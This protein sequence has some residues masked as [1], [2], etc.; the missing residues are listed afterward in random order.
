MSTKKFS[1]RSFLKTA[2]LFAAGGLMAACTPQA[3]P[4]PAAAPVDPTATTA[5]ATE[6]A[7]KATAT[8]VP[9]TAT[10]APT[11][12]SSV[13][14]IW[15]VVGNGEPTDLATV[16]AA[17]NEYIKDKINA[18]LK[19]Q[20]ADWGTYGNKMSLVHSSGEA[21][22]IEFTAPWTNI[23]N[24][25]VANGAF[26]DITDL[27]P[28]YA[29]SLWGSM[30]E[31]TWNAARLGGKIYG[32]INQQR[33]PKVFG[34]IVRKDLAEKYGLDV[35]KLTG[36]ADPALTEFM[37]KVKEGGDVK[38]I[39]TT[40][41]FDAT[42]LGYDPLGPGVVKIDDA[43]GT[44]V[45]FAETPEFRA[46]C[47]LVK[48]WQEAG[49][50][51]SEAMP[52]DV[53]DA[54]MK[55]GEMAMFLTRVVGS[56]SNIDAENKFGMPFL[57]KGMHEPFINTDG[58]V[59]TMNAISV[60]SKNPERALMLLE[61]VNNDPYLFNLICFGVEGKHWEWVDQPNKV[62][63][64]I[65]DSGYAPGTNWEFGNAFNAYYDD[66]TKVGLWEKDAEV[67]RTAKPSPV[68]GFSFDRK[69]VETQMASL[70]PIIDPLYFDLYNG[71]ATDI[72]ASIKTLLDTLKANGH[73]QILAE[74]NNQI[75][76]WKSTL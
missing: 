46:H 23:Y 59:A 76:A 66:P 48:K 6:A 16:E 68:L 11:E 4:T 54:T 17:I 8:I 65:A 58:V 57:S 31:T 40:P 49:F 36:Y 73:D 33:F 5:K 22:D 70:Q 71:L 35:D 41:W 64:A 19:F 21:S 52:D 47:E 9:A 39:S 28:Q 53:A 10:P 61:L 50:F 38:Y 26:V 14:L 67:N 12:L 63:K 75:A 24:Q 34:L 45:T 44:A 32:V 18:T 25:S 60:N 15:H 74:L 30:P 69:P 2:S 56:S 29:P 13:E 62:I 72:D 20:H 27:L 37:T 42:F 43:S 55:A 1:R 3:T 51:P 7:V